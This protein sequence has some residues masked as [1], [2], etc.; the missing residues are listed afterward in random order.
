MMEL[1]G[2]HHRDHHDHVTKSHTLCEVVDCY[3]VFGF[4]GCFFNFN[5]FLY[6]SVF[7]GLLSYSSCNLQNPFF[8]IT[9]FFFFFELMMI[10]AASGDRTR[11]LPEFVS[12]VSTPL[13]F[14]NNK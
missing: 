6:F 5:L 3:G 7:G 11:R 9:F 2:T 10:G 12:K 4:C 14:R 13:D 1:N 8:G